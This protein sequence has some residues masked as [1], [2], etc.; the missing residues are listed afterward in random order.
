MGAWELGS[1]GAWELG[2]LGAWGLRGNPPPPRTLAG[3][4]ARRETSE[5]AAWQ[6]R[7]GL[8]ALREGRAVLAHALREGRWWWWLSL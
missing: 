4:H 7:G 5:L 3:A 2:S 1:L 8:H 6:G